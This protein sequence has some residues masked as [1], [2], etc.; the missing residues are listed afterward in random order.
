MTTQPLERGV[1][2]ANSESQVRAPVDF[3]PKH[4]DAAEKSPTSKPE[5]AN[6]ASRAHLEPETVQTATPEFSA[7]KVT[8]IQTASQWDRKTMT[9]E[10]MRKLTYREL[11]SAVLKPEPFDESA[12]DSAKLELVRR[13]QELEKEKQNLKDQLWRAKGRPSRLVALVMFVVGVIALV[14]AVSLDVTVLAFVGLGLAFWGA[15]LLQVRPSAYLKAEIVKSTAQ[16]SVE[17]VDRLLGDLGCASKG[18]YLP[19]RSLQ[20]IVVFVPSGNNAGSIVNHTSL[21]SMKG[22]IV[23]PPGLSLAALIENEL[24]I[25]ITKSKLVTLEGKLTKILTD[26]LEIVKD[27]EMRLDR[28]QASFKFVQANLADFCNNLRDRTHICSTLGCP[29]C[30]AMGCLL[31]GSSKRPVEFEGEKISKNGQVMEATY[32]IIEED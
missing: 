24:G 4:V 23:V 29:I 19:A 1:T 10:E 32:R 26:D 16:S 14:A 30:S 11:P 15:L 20:R 6:P 31:A 27:F 2:K 13:I 8:N 18:I 12:G 25:D 22:I 9:R 5:L 28:E 17:A 3:P 21:N 7:V